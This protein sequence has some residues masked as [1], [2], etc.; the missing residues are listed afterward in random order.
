MEARILWQ[1]FIDLGAEIS[2]EDKWG[3]I[4][5]YR[6]RALFH[7]DWTQLADVPLTRQEQIFQWRTFRQ[8][9]RDLTD[10]YPTPDEVI[11][12]TPPE[13]NLV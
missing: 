2:D 10:I 5:E 3:M 1:S 11:F 4:R 8:T 7:S 12:P 9:L 13:G 6:N